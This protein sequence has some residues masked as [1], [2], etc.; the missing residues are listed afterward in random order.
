[1]LLGFGR[2]ETESK[3]SQNIDRALGALGEEG[4]KALLFHIC[5]RFN[6]NVG[7]IPRNPE[8]F[9]LALAAILGSGAEVI[10]LAMVKQT[11]SSRD[12][13]GEEREYIEKMAG[14]A[15]AELSIRSVQSGWLT[16]LGLH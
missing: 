7:D 14:A 15:Q 6:F 5:N 10:E 12:S 2:D 8:K 9:G 1:M 13:L 11:L 3:V 16:S 4:E